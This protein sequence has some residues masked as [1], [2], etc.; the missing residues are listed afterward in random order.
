[1]GIDDWNWLGA[2]FSSQRPF[3]KMSGK[4]LPNGWV[5]MGA[6]GLCVVLWP[7]GWFL[8]RPKEEEAEEAKPMQM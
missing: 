1:M 3:N 5:R 6:I 2:P 7:I 4:S 8:I